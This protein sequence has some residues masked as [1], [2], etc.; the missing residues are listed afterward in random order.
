MSNGG[1]GKREGNSK[2]SQENVGIYFKTIRVPARS[3]SQTS[4]HRTK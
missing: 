3:G 4:T 2:F 1:S